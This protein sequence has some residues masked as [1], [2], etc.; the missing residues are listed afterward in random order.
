[1]AL[2]IERF[3]SVEER[4]PDSLAELVP[5]RAPA[6]LNDPYDGEPLRYVK[7]EK[8]Y[9][10]YSIGPD[11]KDDGGETPCVTEAEEGD[12]MIAVPR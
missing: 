4:L 8:G 3:R 11:G 1:M 12:I 2:A 6:V 9:I 7:R 10:V 5:S